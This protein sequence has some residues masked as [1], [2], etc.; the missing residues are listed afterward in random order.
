MEQNNPHDLT[1]EERAAIGVLRFGAAN[2]TSIL[3]IQRA[4]HSSYTAR[5]IRPPANLSIPNLMDSALSKGIAVIPSKDAAGYYIADSGA[6]LNAYLV[7][8]GEL[9]RRINRRMHSTAFVLR[10]MKG[11]W[12]PQPPELLSSETARQRMKAHLKEI[13]DGAIIAHSGCITGRFTSDTPALEIGEISERGNGAP[14]S[15]ADTPH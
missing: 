6:E 3:S 1:P 10:T 7:R 13:S 15:E 8:L 9:R 5:R 4:V 11:M 14:R 12:G 2:P